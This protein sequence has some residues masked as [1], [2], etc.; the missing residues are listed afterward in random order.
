MKRVVFSI[1]V[2]FALSACALDSSP[3]YAH[4]EPVYRQQTVYRSQITYQQK[5]NQDCRNYYQNHQ[6]SKFE[7]D[8]KID[9][10]IK[11]RLIRS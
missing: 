1:I 6:I 5:V 11:S 3:Q 10:C 2:C 9:K 8:N 7:K 4:V